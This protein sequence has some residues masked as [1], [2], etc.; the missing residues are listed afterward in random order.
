[1]PV[2]VLTYATQQ[3]NIQ[4][5]LTRLDERLGLTDVPG[6]FMERLSQLDLFP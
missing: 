3:V 2:V 1:M 5:L 6:S 4:R